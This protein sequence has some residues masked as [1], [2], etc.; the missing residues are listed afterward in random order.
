[1]PAPYIFKSISN[2][3]GHQYPFYHVSIEDLI[4]IE[5]ATE[6]SASLL[7]ESGQVKFKGSTFPVEN[8]EYAPERIY[9]DV[10]TGNKWCS[11]PSLQYPLYTDPVVKEIWFGDIIEFLTSSNNTQATISK[12]W[13][14]FCG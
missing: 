6:V 13:S 1:I 14:I 12:G 10:W 7:Q 11:T 4:R 2:Q 5:L 8:I 3:I 9:D